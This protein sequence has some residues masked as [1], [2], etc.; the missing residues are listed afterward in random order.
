MEAPCFR[1]PCFG[2]I[3]AHG[4]RCKSASDRRQSTRRATGGAA[5]FRDMSLAPRRNPQSLGVEDSAWEPFATAELEVGDGHVLY[6]EEV[7]NPDGLPIVYLHGGPGSGC[8]VGARRPF[9][10]QR[11]RAVLF[12]QRAS[13]RSRPH[14]SED[15]VDWA[16]IDL[17][18]HIADIEALRETLGVARWA[19]FGTSWGSVLGVA[20]A[21][22]HP[23]SVTA[24]VVAAVSTG[25]AEDIDWLTVD[26]G[27]FFPEEWEA[28]RGHV[29]PR[30][31]H[32]RLVDAHNE[33]V[34][35]HDPA[36]HRDPAGPVADARA[37]WRAPRALSV[38][39]PLL[40]AG[41]QEASRVRAGVRAVGRL[42][43]RSTDQ[44]CRRIRCHSPCMSGPPCPSLS[45]IISALP[46]QA[47]WS[48]HGPRSGLL[49][50]RRPWINVP[51][52]PVSR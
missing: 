8:T 28:F 12:D 21:Q 32:L 18:H 45:R 47:L 15:D 44:S 40:W 23:G 5:S 42:H 46:G 13:G 25:T 51:G 31:R 38:R 41:A 2:S 30:L 34:M 27:R 24:V 39:R 11:H 26:A 20:Y 33:L 10:P 16:A 35:D 4:N 22:R 14:A 9:D 19:V 1:H 50:S 7:G 49:T 36:V 48:R 43:R 37:D 29:P 3:R 17:D 52:A 6:Y